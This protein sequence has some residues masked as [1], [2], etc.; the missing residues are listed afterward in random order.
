MDYWGGRRAITGCAEPLLLRGSHIKPWT[1]CETDAERLDVYNGLL[2]AAHL[3]AAFDAGLIDFDDAADPL[4]RTLRAGRSSRG[5]SPRRDGT[6]QA[7][8]RAPHL[9]R[10]APRPSAD[11]RGILHS[12]WLD[13]TMEHGSG[14][15]RRFVSA[16]RPAKRKFEPNVGRLV[17]IRLMSK[18][19]SNAYRMGQVN[20]YGE[21][22]ASERVFESM[23]GRR[24]EQPA[25]V[26]IAANLRITVLPDSTQWQTLTNADASNNPELSWEYFDG[27]GWRRLAD[28]FSDATANLSNTGKVRF[29]VPD[30]LTTTKIGGQE[31]YWIRARLIGGDYGQPSFLIDAT[32]VPEGDGLLFD[33]KITIDRSNVHPPEIRSMSATFELTQTI[34]PELTLTDNNLTLVDQ[35]AAATTKGAVFDLFA[36]A[37]TL[38]PAAPEPALYVSL[39]KPFAAD[40]LRLLVDAVEQEGHAEVVWQVFAEGRW[41]EVPVTGDDPTHG[42]LRPGIITLSVRARPTRRDLFGHSGFWLRARL[43]GGA[44]WQ[45]KLNGIYLNAAPAEQAETIR[46]ELLGSTTGEPDAEFRLVRA[47]ILREGAEPRDGVE[48]R[49]GI[50][51][52]DGIELRVRERLGSEEREALVAA[53]GKDA[54]KSGLP[55]LPGDWV[56]WRPVDSLVEAKAEARVFMLDQRTGAIR[57]G[58]GRQ[59]RSPPAG[60]DSV[61]AFRYRVGG[62]ERGNVLAYTVTSLKSAVTGVEAV[63]N[64]LPTRGG[65]DGR[66]DDSSC[67]QA[68]ATVRHVNRA[69]TPNDV[70]ALALDFAPEIVRARC[71][72][73]TEP[74]APIV[75]A[76]AIASAEPMPQPTVAMR[77]GL[78]EYLSAKASNSWAAAGFRVVGPEFVRLQLKVEL[79]LAASSPAALPSEVRDRLLGFLHPTTGGHDGK[80]WPF[81]RGVWPSDVHRAL[82]DTLGEADV[83]RLEITRVDGGDPETIGAT[84]VMTTIADQDDVTVRLGESGQ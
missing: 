21:S 33:Q 1:Q 66:A 81:G 8:P 68:V 13:Q 73:P 30:D 26:T 54:I 31:D 62:G 56:L 20:S 69:I 79:A 46:D 5:Q 19:N 55:D 29:E 43:L 10:L 49:D 65:S 80:G 23:R 70:E 84:S 53:L 27:R 64:P 6:R 3:D 24:G 39:S 9:S 40:A 14:P 11:R 71:F 78:A 57:F 50:G 22:R 72:R 67:A 61:R 25:G 34:A 75:V 77:D 52:R 2:L 63:T 58:N 4:R 83:A 15:R 37:V 35:T 74:E 47:P 42:L 18:G 76:V 44:A 7:H 32:P 38:D 48:P 28:G 60:T 41:R 17:A 12:R 51:L 59:G 36:A 45:P 82:A 16:S